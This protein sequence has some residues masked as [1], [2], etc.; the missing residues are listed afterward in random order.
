MRAKEIL[1]KAVIQAIPVFAMR[2]CKIPKSMCREITD[3]MAVFWWG[4]TETQKKMH[5]SAWWRMCTPK[6]DGA[7][8]FGDL[9][10]FNLAMLVKQTW[11]LLCNPNS[12][13]AQVLRAKYYPDGNLLNAGPKKGSSFTWQSEISGLQTFKKGHIWR[14]GNGQNIDIWKDHWVLGMPSRKIDTL[15]GHVIFKKVSELIDTI[16]GEWDEAIIWDIFNPLDAQKVLEIPPSQNLEEDFVAWHETKS[17][18]FSVWSAYYLEWEHQ[19]GG[20]LR[21]R[22][23]QGASTQNP[24][25]EILWKLNIPSKINFFGWRA[26]HGL[27]PGV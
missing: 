3:A 9:H 23:G 7:M 19:Y 2:V 22:D 27:I 12:L 1:L 24:I 4:A 25:W 14:V 15:C 6:K 20:R 8:G 18:I 17:F 16:L 11:R 5:W 26:L 21:R 10:A 13:C